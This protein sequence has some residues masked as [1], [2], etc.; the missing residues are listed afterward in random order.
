MVEIKINTVKKIKNAL[1]VHTRRL[2]MAGETT[3][4]LEGRATEISQT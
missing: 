2:D 4:E 3:N 1:Y